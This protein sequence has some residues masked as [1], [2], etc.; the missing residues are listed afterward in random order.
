MQE[1]GYWL[2]LVLFRA[3]ETRVLEQHG[4][5]HTAAAL[6]SCYIHTHIHTDVH[7]DLYIFY[8]WQINVELS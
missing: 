2:M 6:Q 1:Y 5:R 7:T 4:S 3:M 8:Y